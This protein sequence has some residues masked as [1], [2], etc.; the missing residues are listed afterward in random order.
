MISD[1]CHE[2]ESIDYQNQEQRAKKKKKI[3]IYIW[4]LARDA[5]LKSTF[6]GKFSLYG[7]LKCR[8]LSKDNSQSCKDIIVS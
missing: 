2:K 4:T 6:T 8:V 1:T 3:T 5:I 7:F